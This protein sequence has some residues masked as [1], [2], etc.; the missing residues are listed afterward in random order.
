MI[1]HLGIKSLLD[2]GCG[3]GVSTSWFVLHGLEFVQCVEGSHDAVSQSIVPKAEGY[4]RVVE[5]DF[6]LGPWWP[7]RTVDAVWCVEFTEHVGRNF[8]PNYLTAFRSA[9]LIFVTH[10]NWGG[11]HHVEVHD[12]EWWRIRWEAAGLVYSDLLTA[13][14]RS[15][16]MKDRRSNIGGME[17]NT[18]GQHIWLSVQVSE[19]LESNFDVGMQSTLTFSPLKGIY[20]SYGS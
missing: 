15:I 14:A 1:T 12:D 18:A 7:D 16:A 17:T 10:S 11:W 9:A 2:V 8:Q 4:E 6:S 19:F 20:Q 13:S 3:K 5:H